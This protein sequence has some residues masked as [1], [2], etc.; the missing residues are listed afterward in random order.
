MNEQILSIKDLNAKPCPFCG[1][2][3]ITVVQKYSSGKWFINHGYSIG[4][5]S[6]GCIACHTYARIFKT[7]KEAI[8][9]WNKR[10]KVGEI[11]E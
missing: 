7:E 8:E 6:I 11:N 4:C 9:A 10:S 3:Y 1:D 5:Q 2:T